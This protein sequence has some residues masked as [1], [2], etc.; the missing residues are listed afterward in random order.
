VVD[1]RENKKDRNVKA[2]LELREVNGND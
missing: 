2:A 1:P